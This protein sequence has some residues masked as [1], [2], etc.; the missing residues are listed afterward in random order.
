MKK[1]YLILG[2]IALELAAFPA[3]AQM[4]DRVV[5]EAKPK[6]TA[7]EI[8]TPAAGQSRFLVASNAPF[9][10]Q[11][12][13]VLGDMAVSVHKSGDLNGSRFGDNAQTP[14]ET[15]TCTNVSLPTDAI[16]YKASQKTARAR[17]SILSQAV[18]FEFSYD[19]LARPI[20][21]FKAGETVQSRPKPC[22]GST[23]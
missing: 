21:T 3:A 1:R 16:I 17:G 23:V 4:V 14:G 19:V 10:V 22:S 8:P 7:V 13:N 12:S 2:V 15:E 5:F 6:V 18:I 20:I 11:S 9:H